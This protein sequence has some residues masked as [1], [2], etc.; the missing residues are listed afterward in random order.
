[1]HRVSQN[2]F[3]E[4][5]L[6]RGMYVMAQAKTTMNK[7]FRASLCVVWRFPA[8]PCVFSRFDTLLDF[9]GLSN[10][11][12]C[13]QVLLSHMGKVWYTQIFVA[14]C[15]STRNLMAQA[16]TSMN[17]AFRAFPCVSLG[18][19]TYVS[20]RFFSFSC[21]P[22]RCL[23]FLRVVIVLSVC[24]CFFCNWSSVVFFF[25]RGHGEGRQKRGASGGAL[26]AHR[27]GTIGTQGAQALGARH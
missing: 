20:L 23:T 10:G 13:F 2:L 4:F 26:K 22:T 14:F 24:N 9:S 25:P 27:K 16:R 17:E 8:L 12:Q 11:S 5:V 19:L 15:A 18:C 21:V 1:M 3:A 6:S 7:A